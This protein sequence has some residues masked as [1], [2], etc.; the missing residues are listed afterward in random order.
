MVAVMA[1]RRCPTCARR[2]RSDERFCPQ[3]GAGLTDAQEPGDDPNLGRVLAGRYRIQ[4]LLGRGGMGVVYEA[5]HVPLGRAV[6]VKL[7]AAER[8]RRPEAVQRFLREA[9][10][11]ARLKSPWAVMLL[12]F[13]HDEGGEPFLVMELVR[14]ETLRARLQREGAL[15]VD[16][17]VAIL[18]QV[19]RVLSEAHAEGVVHR[20]L[21]PD[22][23]ALEAQAGDDSPPGPPGR[24][25]GGAP[26][27]RGVYV[28]VL[29]FG[30]ARLIDDDAPLTE[31]SQVPG[32]PQY[33]APER[34]S[35]EPLGP[36]SDIYALGI[37]AYECLTGAAPYRGSA[38]EVMHA[39]VTGR[40]RPFEEAA[41]GR[42]IP[43]G[44]AA[45]VWRSLA[46]SPELRPAD[47]AAFVAA[48]EAV[49]PSPGAPAPSLPS[50]VFGLVRKP[51]PTRSRLGGP[52]VAVIAA[53]VLAAGAV[54]WLVGR[55]DT[56]AVPGP[57]VPIV[58][59]APEPAAAPTPAP[60]P[61]P[62]PEPAPAVVATPT[63][64]EPV[65]QPAPEPTTPTRAR[66]ATR[67]PV[68]LPVD[69][70]IERVDRLLP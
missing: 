30:I 14:G 24:E 8:A 34:V 29:D 3:D 52:T 54:G 18:R 16:E 51:A 5:E 65:P 27:A 62:A 28:K 66:P 68:D 1:L 40:P 37:I 15:P 50:D 63:P 53:L 22:N 58:I 48:L 10:A 2:Y 35:G 21:K 11:V 45:L 44:L 13:G 47:G 55:G 69:P 49:A 19:G 41:P 38:W 59:S 31:T 33:I 43:E 9:R 6:A 20:D 70:T 64:S 46:R 23:I 36:A 26:K 57:V 25:P 4:G 56:V 32:T 60:A 42:V 12:D 39:H 7:L 61:A 67:P 17:V